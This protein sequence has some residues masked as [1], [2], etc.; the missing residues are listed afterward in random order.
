MRTCVQEIIDK[1]ELLEKWYGDL[2]RYFLNFI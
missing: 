2:E 1:K